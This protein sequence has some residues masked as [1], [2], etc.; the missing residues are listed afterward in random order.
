MLR[1]QIDRYGVEAVMG[2]AVLSARE[3]RDMTLV[4]SIYS[5]FHSRAGSDNWAEWSNNHP[6]AARLL[7]SAMIAEMADN[8]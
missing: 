5:A 7:E 3:I 1:W 2:R 6:D 8:G 4:E